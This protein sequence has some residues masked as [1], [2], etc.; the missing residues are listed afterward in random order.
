LL[1]YLQ[2]TKAAAFIEVYELT[3]LLKGYTLNLEATIC[4]VVDGLHVEVVGEVELMPLWQLDGQVSY[5]KDDA[6]S[7]DAPR[8]AG[9]GL[10]VF[11][12]PGPTT[13][14]I[15]HNGVGVPMDDEE[16]V[17]V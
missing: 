12:S 3:T 9:E 4:H 10:L 16:G 11:G 5:V 2:R 15:V 6:H 13:L 7:L 17:E 8:L 14:A 1:A